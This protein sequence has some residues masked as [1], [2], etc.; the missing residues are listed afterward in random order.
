M[1]HVRTACRQ[2]TFEALDVRQELTGSPEDM[3]PPVEIVN[4][5]AWEMSDS[6]HAGMIKMIVAKCKCKCW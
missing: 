4:L 6:V 5:F 1:R 2:R 3:Q